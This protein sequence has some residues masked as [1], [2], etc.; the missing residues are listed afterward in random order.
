[1]LI[2]PP[3]VIRTR[4][5][6]ETPPAKPTYVNPYANSGPTPGTAYQGNTNSEAGSTRKKSTVRTNLKRKRKREELARAAEMNENMVQPVVGDGRH[7]ADGSLDMELDEEDVQEQ[8]EPVRPYV[9]EHNRKSSHPPH[10]ITLILTNPCTSLRSSASL[11][12]IHTSVSAS[13]RLETFSNDSQPTRSFP[14]RSYYPATSP[15]RTT[16]RTHTTKPVPTSP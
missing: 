5:Y 6:T 13:I 8:D 1:M 7:E 4:W 9:V 10:L 14:S 11:T 12:R 16:K 2:N 3:S 15:R